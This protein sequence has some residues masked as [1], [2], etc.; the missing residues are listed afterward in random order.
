MRWFANARQRRFWWVAAIIIGTGAGMSLTYLVATHTAFGRSWLLS[1]LVSSVN[2]V[3]KG[4][5]TLRIGTL[6]SISPGRVVAENVALV[7]T[8]GVPVVVAKRLEGTLSVSGLFS[9]AIHIRRLLIDGLTIDLKQDT[10]GRA[11]NLAYI[12]AGDTATSPTHTPGFGDDVR[13]DSID[14]RNGDVRTSAPWS[15][16]P[17]FTGAAR[18]SV[19]AVRDSL[20]DLVRT[21]NG[22]LFERRAITLAHVAAHDVVVVDVQHRPASLQLDALQGAL[23]D[24]P[25]AIRHASGQ[26]VWTSDSLRL[27]LTTVAL[28]HSTGSA[29][30]TI[31]WN[32]PGPVRYDVLVHA[33]AGLADLAWVWD[34]L[35]PEGRGRAVVRMRTLADAYDTEYA[36][37][38]LDVSS[39][40]SRIRGGIA[41]TVRP[42]DFLLHNVDLTFSPLRSDLLRRISYDA[43]P[44]EVQGP[45]TGRLVARQGG[46][47]SAFRLDL[48]DA[49]FADERVATRGGA[50]PAI[51]SVTV[52][53]MVFLP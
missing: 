20:H 5:G 11:W 42:A 30:G 10:T 48:L 50:E 34:A 27:A 38:S 46:P 3:F 1:T 14:V 15:P 18:D 23:S 37:D 35:P 17:I 22:L 26:I 25:V 52:R 47:L 43:L 6:R 7:D 13:I 49:R 44:P 4:R 29:V 45:F 39:G 32:Q 36:L 16:H 21:P 12:I 28:P 24:P 31:A 19:I 40:L 51:S 9:K 41:M 33:D 2:G 53:G 8:A